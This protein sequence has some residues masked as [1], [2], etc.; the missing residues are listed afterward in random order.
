M[1][2]LPPPPLPQNESAAPDGPTPTNRRLLGGVAVVGALVAVGGIVAVSQF[3][4]ADE[5]S[6]S[7]TAAVAQTDEGDEPPAGEDA[8]SDDGSGTPTDDGPFDNLPFDDLPFD[9]LVPPELKAEFEAFEQCL[10]EQLGGLFSEFEN[11]ES[12]LRQ[13]WLM[14]QTRAVLVITKQVNAP[15][16]AWSSLAM[17]C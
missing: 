17:P 2:P 15:L 8:P 3:V 10:D 14:S 12:F 6:I 16:P 7:A 9:D 11:M 1:A 13:D 5:P 4:P